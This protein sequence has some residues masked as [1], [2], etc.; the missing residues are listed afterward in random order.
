MNL[1]SFPAIKGILFDIEGVLCIGSE[2][3]EGAPET[4]RRIRAA[5]YLRRF[6]TNTSTL[7]RASL[8]RKLEHLGFEVSPG[9]ILSAPQA[10]LLHLQRLRNPRCALLLADDVKRDFAEI[11]AVDI[12]E[13]DTIVL[14]DIGEAWSYPLLDRIFN[15]LMAGATLIA[16]H[17]NRFWET[18]AGLH[19]DIGGFVAA[20]EYC[21][22]TKAVVMGKPSP[23]FFRVALRDMG[24]EP[25]QAAIVGDDIDADI[26]GGQNLGLTG[27]LVKTGKY[28]EAHVRSSPVRPDRI[29]D[30]ISAMNRDRKDL[31]I[32]GEPA[33]GR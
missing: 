29:I 15:R 22:G 26:A 11:A 33:Q 16:V 30:S 31:D 3:I 21:S 2:A 7:S 8:L 10:A 23:D 32:Q 18:G 6:V 20:L 27:I 17:R 24:L 28:R 12:E 1:S 19:I 9:E 5:G 14:G 25:E 4:L 13:A